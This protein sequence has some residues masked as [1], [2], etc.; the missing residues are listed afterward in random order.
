MNDKPHRKWRLLQ[1]ESSI[2]CNLNCIMCPWTEER[3]NVSDH[4]RMNRRIWDAIKPHLKDIESIDFTGGGEPLLHPD[5]SEWIY[6]AHDAGCKTGF[7]TNGTLLTKTMTSN[8]LD[9]GI[10]WICFSVDGADQGT[11]NRIRQGADFDRVCR[12][13]NYFCDA[14]SKNGPTAMINYVIMP[15]NCHQMEAIVRLAADLGIDRV[16]FK[17][18]D[19][20]RGDHGTG[21]GLFGPSETKEIRKHQKA[22]SRAKKTGRKLKVKTTAFSFTPEELPVCVQDPRDSLF[23]RYNGIVSPCINLAIG[24][25]T[26][27]LGNQAIMPSVHYGRLPD[28]DFDDIRDNKHYRFF[29]DRFESRVTSNEKGFMQIDLSEPSLLKLKAAK[30]AA[31]DAMPAAPEGCRVCHY[32]YGI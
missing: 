25:P 23:I 30:Q 10:D 27:F 13:I 14:R 31:I 32:L 9:A 4:G 19:V 7:L 17:Q 3:R 21:S 24:G 28:L 12:N 15:M 1:L 18:C 5:L 26:T 2:A 8:M 6:D 22:L 29:S 20:I 11:F 16:I